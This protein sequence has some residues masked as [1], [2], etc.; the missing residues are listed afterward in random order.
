MHVQIISPLLLSDVFEN[1]MDKC[2]EIYELD[3]AQFLSAPGLAREACL[4]K[5]KIITLILVIILMKIKQNKY[6]G[7]SIQNINNRFW[8]R[9]KKMHYQI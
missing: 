6:S 9:K 1:F 4:K 7:S 3:P 2:I 5:K 8:I